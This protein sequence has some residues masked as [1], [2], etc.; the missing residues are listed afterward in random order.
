MLQTS[1]S[2]L[3]GQGKIGGKIYKKTPIKRK[4]NK[5]WA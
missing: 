2:G 1:T 5:L 3:E 4:T